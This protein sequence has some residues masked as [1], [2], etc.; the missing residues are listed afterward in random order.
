MEEDRDR[1]LLM[2]YLDVIS[3]HMKLK[4]AKSIQ[5]LGM[6]DSVK[7]FP[8]ENGQWNRV[9]RFLSKMEVGGE[10]VTIDCISR[11][12]NLPCDITTVEIYP[13][14]GA[15]GLVLWFCELF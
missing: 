1:R 13:V 9:F 3:F 4:F 12:H 14:F 10:Q 7:V 6:E 11:R 2:T 8:L 5:W 15:R